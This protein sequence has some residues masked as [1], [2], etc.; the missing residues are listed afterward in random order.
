MRLLLDTHVLLWLAEGS[1]ALPDASRTLIEHA[2][3]GEGLA[4][5]SISF[6]E[7]AMLAHRSRISLSQPLAV[8]R[9]RVRAQPG[10]VELAVD[11]D[12]AIE[13]VQ[14]PGELHPDPA[15]RMIAATARIHGCRLATRDCRLLDYAASGHLRAHAV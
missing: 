3:A 8:W 10:V 14:L 6:W 13:A 7:I 1:D 12:V 4:V 11:G 15:D 9:G 5:S 2:A